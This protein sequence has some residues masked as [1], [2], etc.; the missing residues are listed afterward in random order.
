MC[1]RKGWDVRDP[2]KARRLFGALPVAV[3]S[4][5]EDGIV[6]FEPLILQ[7]YCET[8]RPLREAHKAYGVRY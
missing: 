8:V 1:D 6:A 2:G 7:G 4:A 5:G 3:D